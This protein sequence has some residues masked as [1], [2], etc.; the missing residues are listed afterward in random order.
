METNAVKKMKFHH[1]Q[2]TNEFDAV[3]K[4]KSETQF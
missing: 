4:F 3:V 1:I 2:L